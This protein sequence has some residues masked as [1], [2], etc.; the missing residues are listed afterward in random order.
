MMT[1][2]TKT[3]KKKKNNTLVKTG[4]TKSFILVREKRDTY[5]KISKFCQGLVFTSQANVRDTMFPILM[6]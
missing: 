6:Q 1:A 3:T 4:W 5:E 2:T